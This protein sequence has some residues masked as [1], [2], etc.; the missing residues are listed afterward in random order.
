VRQRYRLT[1]LLGFAALGTAPLGA[2]AMDPLHS[3][4]FM[5][6]GW[7]GG[8]SLGTAQ[9]EGRFT[10]RRDLGGRVLLRRDHMTYAVGPKDRRTLDILLV[11]APGAE[12]TGFQANY[13]DSDGHV[14]NFKSA[15]V[16]SDSLVV[17]VSESGI[18]RPMFRLT[19]EKV[20]RH[21]LRIVFSTEGKA[22]GVVTT[23]ADGV[24]T[25]YDELLFRSAP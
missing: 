11:M 4:E 18:G 9:S 3:L 10:I 8:P 14:L 25:R 13:F 15:R 7:S 21:G 17:F 20:G 19:Y 5:E 23:I 12:G 6:G 24:A 1:L 16:I 22:S 2:Q